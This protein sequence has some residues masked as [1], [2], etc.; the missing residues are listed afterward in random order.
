MRGAGADAAVGGATLG[1]VR[2]A[3]ADAAVGGATLEAVRGA[4]ADAAVEGATLGAGEDAAVV[5]TESELECTTAADPS[6]VVTL[7]LSISCNRLDTYNIEASSR[8]TPSADLTVP[9]IIS[10]HEE[11]AYIDAAITAA[12]AAICTRR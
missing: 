7:A 3:G 8:E 12:L 5:L 1:A 11:G 9:R 2:G 10:G 6:E 4:G